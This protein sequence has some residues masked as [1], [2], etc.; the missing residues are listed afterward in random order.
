MRSEGEETGERGKRGGEW[1]GEEWRGV[2]RERVEQR[3]CLIESLLSNEDY[4]SNQDV[5]RPQLHH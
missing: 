2:E 3:N 1:R 5:Y 4:H